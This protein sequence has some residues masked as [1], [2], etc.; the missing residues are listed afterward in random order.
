MK[1]VEYLSM[2]GYAAYVWPA[3]GL[4]CSV[5]VAIWLTV[6]QQKRRTRL[7]LH[8]WFKS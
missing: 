4:V 6:K 8:E 7:K 2:G 5:L 3:Y 1:V